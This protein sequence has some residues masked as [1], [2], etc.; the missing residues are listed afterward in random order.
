MKIDNNHEK[1]SDFYRT[2]LLMEDAIE[3]SMQKRTFNK[4]KSMIFP[5]LSQ[6]YVLFTKLSL[7][8]IKEKKSVCS[9]M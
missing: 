3:Q 8:K 4:Y 1:I 6:L 9:N 7:K 2:P 5:V